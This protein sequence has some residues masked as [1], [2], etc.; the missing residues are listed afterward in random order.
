MLEEMI[1][2]FMVSKDRIPNAHFLILT[3]SDHGIV[4]EAI[5]K[6]RQSLSDFTILNIPHSAM[7]D[8]IGLSSVALIF[9]K[10]IFSK[11]SSSPTKFS[12]C[13]G[14][15]IPVIINS[16]IGDCDELIRNNSTGVI[17]DKFENTSYKKALEELL[18]LMQDNSGL[19]RRCRE[20]AEDFFPL[21]RGVDA[22]D[23]IYLKLLDKN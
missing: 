23:S 8:Y 7:P 19:R 20:L 5:D 14:C 1:D 15:G 9:I 18:V 3:M 11:L 4:S 21:K 2:F 6:K 12:E 13:L 22:Y 10:P 16:N 17:V